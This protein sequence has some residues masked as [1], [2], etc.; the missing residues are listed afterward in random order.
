MA[1]L[2]GFP[3]E[4]VVP[5]SSLRPGDRVH[6][7]KVTEGVVAERTSPN[8]PIYVTATAE[9]GPIITVFEAGE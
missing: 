3:R 9:H 5:Q 8:D 7:W 2:M 1:L 6:I 4:A